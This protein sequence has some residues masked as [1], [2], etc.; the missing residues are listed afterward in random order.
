MASPHLCNRG[1]NDWAVGRRIF[2]SFIICGVRSGPVHSE[3]TV[4]HQGRQDKL[5][6]RVPHAAL[7][8]TE[9]HQHCF[10]EKIRQWVLL[11][12]HPHVE[13]CFGLVP[14]DAS[15][16]FLEDIKGSTLTNWVRSGQ[17]S[18]RSILSLLMQICHGVEY[19]HAHG[20]YHQDI[21]P[22]SIIITSSSLAKIKEVVR[23]A[24]SDKGQN[25]H[26]D[27]KGLG[28]L[29]QMMLFSERPAAI[30]RNGN[31]SEEPD[32][33]L[34]QAALLRSILDRCSAPAGRCY[35]DVS[36]LRHDLNRVYNL[37][38]GLDC[39]YH[40]L[41]TD[42]RAESF[43]NQAVVCFAIGRFREAL[44]KLQQALIV[45]DRLPEAVYNLILYKLRSGLF[46]PERILLM[47]DSALADSSVADQ[48]A[49]LKAQ[50]NKMKGEKHRKMPPL[51]HFLLCSSPQ[52]LV[53]Y[54]QARKRMEKCREIEHHFYNLRYEACLK[55]LLSAW[56]KR[57][58][59]K[60]AFLAGI[61][62]RLSGKSDKREIAGVQRYVTLQGLGSAVEHLAYLPGTRKI[63]EAGSDDRIRIRNYGHA[64]KVS[65]INT[66]GQAVTALAVS[67]DGRI[68]AV[69][70]DE[71]EV[72][73]WQSGSGHAQLWRARLHHG[74]VNALAFSRD[75]RF[76]ASCGTDGT[77]VIRTIATG[78]E[79][80]VPA[81]DNRQVTCLSFVAD[82]LDLV[83]A[84]DNGEIKIWSERGKKCLHQLAAH[85]GPVDSLSLAPQGDFFASAGGEEIKIWDIY[86]GQC[87][88]QLPGHQGGRTLVLL[89]DDHRH[90]VSAGMDDMIRIRDLIT[91]DVV[92]VLDGRGNGIR[93]LAKGS[94]PHFF[95]AG[96][97]G[98]ALLI[99]KIIYHLIFN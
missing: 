67:P 40:T 52:S 79:K 30:G 86:S 42:L 89:L 21:L 32:R 41:E 33:L 96:Q 49:V 50:V 59:A 19:L 88:Q 74:R 66:G 61:L 36:S 18:L 24:L 56:S 8:K 12:M 83:T 93:C 60:D 15:A 25:P 98:G 1:D 70:T 80:M 44:V 5:V 65:T 37:A 39:P 99:W 95:F 57:R 63:I 34:S 68:I 47:I 3:Y 90:L 6:V 2:G 4:S 71:G 53:L 22:D 64:I 46:P 77:M 94:Q 29:L 91:D 48:L 20:V 76:F 16:Y 82:G 13:A 9:V 58:F 78:R 87:L 10:A 26:A 72:V 54:R 45:H 55:S 69:G 43:N 85:A 23:P 14:G 97:Q 27:I 92:A 7:F 75:G 11:G 62:D 38:Y 81:W 73:F 35:P 17:S 84:N 28:G 31:V 51:P